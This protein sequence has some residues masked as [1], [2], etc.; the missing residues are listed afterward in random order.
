ME[1]EQS[2]V[3][4]RKAIAAQILPALRGTVSS[5]RRVIAHHADE[6]D[7]LDFAGSKWAKELSA[8]APVARI[9]FCELESALGSSIGIP[10]RKT[11]TVL[12]QRIQN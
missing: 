6:D 8:L 5:N 7:A 9:I 4:D 12:K 10:Q 3:Q 11:F 1:F 2:P